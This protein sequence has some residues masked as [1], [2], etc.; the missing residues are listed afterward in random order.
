M[1]FSISGTQ[2]FDTVSQPVLLASKGQI[3]YMNPAAQRLAAQTLSPI[4]VGAAPPEEFPQEA[5][6][7]A[8]LT[9]GSTEWQVRT[10][11]LEQG[12]L[13]QLTPLTGTDCLNSENAYLLSV[14]LKSTMNTMLA[15][16]EALQDELVETELERN[17]ERFASL[18]RSYYR[19]LH[20]ID[21]L[22][23]YSRMTSTPARELIWPEAIELGEFCREM[24]R[25]LKPLIEMA[26]HGLTL[27][28]DATLPPLYVKGER[29]MLERLVCQL[30][31]NA[32]HAGGEI[33]ISLSRQQGLALLAV[34]DNGS[35]IPDEVLNDPFTSAPTSSGT[36]SGG[37]GFG[38]P[39]CHKIAQLHGGNL[40]LSRS[41][42][43]TSAAVS[44]PLL[45]PEDTDSELQSRTV[46]IVESISLP[47]LELSSD[48]PVQ[49]YDPAA[50]L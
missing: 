6:T 29:R 39:I 1:D 31:A 4:T 45:R 30:C 20:T 7:T 43:G 5:D 48:L 9:L 46:N 33:S 47:L 28:L 2:Y 44:L 25:E 23:V 50:F 24:Y 36:Y 34:Q 27:K 21:S 22:S 32:L 15:S 49:C 18:N 16:L 42:Q 38:L 40:V 19:L 3:V 35:G 13:Y 14:G 26:G 11:A 17:R 37:V 41:R 8:V 10:R 12:I